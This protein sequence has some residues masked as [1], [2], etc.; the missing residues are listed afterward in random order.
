VRQRFA[1]FAAGMTAAALLTAGGA[2]MWHYRE[3]ATRLVRAR[4]AQPQV[5][6]APE[7]QTSNQMVADHQ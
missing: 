4:A 7:Y 1:A 6:H 3:Y 2:T 5:V